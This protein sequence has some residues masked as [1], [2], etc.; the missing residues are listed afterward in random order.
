MNKNPLDKKEVIE[1]AL[2]LLQTIIAV[3]N[4]IILLMNI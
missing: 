4:I 2:L 1:L 3:L